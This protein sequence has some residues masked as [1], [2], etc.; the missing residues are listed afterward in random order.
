MY[1]WKRY[2]EQGELCKIYFYEGTTFDDEKFYGRTDKLPGIIY[3]LHKR[4]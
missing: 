1:V 3:A 2:N 4:K